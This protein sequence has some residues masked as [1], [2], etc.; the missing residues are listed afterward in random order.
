MKR[1]HLY[2]TILSLILIISCLGCGQATPVPNLT[3][4]QLQEFYPGELS[5]VNHIEIR[6]GST[7]ELRTFTDKQQVQNWLDGVSNL[8]FKP[9]PNQDKRVG[10]LYAVDLF[11]GKDSKLRFTPGDIQGN[12]YVYNKDLEKQIR[13]LFE[14]KQ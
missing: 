7:G 1:T 9:D 5:N 2:S 4:K 13:E 3:V 14:S 11:E 12:Y 8:A 6:S 10:F